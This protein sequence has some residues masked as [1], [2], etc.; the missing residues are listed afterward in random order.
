MLENLKKDLAKVANREKA[1]F[2]KRFFKAGKGDYAEGDI[3]IGVT[4]PKTRKIV[5]KY[6][7]MPLVEVGQLLKSPIHEHRLAALL[8]LVWQFEHGN[9][10]QQEKIYK[11]YLRNTKYINNWDL[12]D[13]SAPYIVGG[14]LLNQKNRSILDTLALSN[15]LWKQRIAMLATYQMIKQKEFG[16][17]LRIAQLLLPHKHD[18]I[19]KAV[20]WMLREVGNR[21]LAVEEKFLKKHYKTMPRTTLRYAIEKFPVARR[22]KYL[23]GEI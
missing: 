20:G 5:S 12:V 21:D 7:S 8:I 1:I 10:Q 16:D 6:R 3:L 11:L 14:Y 17:A 22:Q 19:H 13:S 23:K 18:L 15:N 9:P 4:V 2:L